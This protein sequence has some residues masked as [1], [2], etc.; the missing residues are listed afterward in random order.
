MSLQPGRIRQEITL[1]HAPSK[2]WRF[3]TEPD[4]VSKWWAPCDI[5]AEVGNEFRFDMGKW[6]TARCKVVV[7]EPEQKLS[8]TFGNEG[9]DTTITWTLRPEGEGTALELV[10]DGFDLDSPLAKAAFEGMSN[11]WPFVLGRLTSSLDG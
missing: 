6:G 4:L 8:Y 1:R 2:V 11:G 7:A 9:L 3:L 10:Q 5:V